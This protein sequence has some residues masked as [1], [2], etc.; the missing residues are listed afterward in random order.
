MA[1]DTMW[2]KTRGSGRWFNSIY[3][4]WYWLT[5]RGEY[6]EL[7]MR[8]PF[9]TDTIL[10]HWN[11]IRF[12]KELLSEIIE[13]Q[14]PFDVLL[15]LKYLFV[16]LP[17]VVCERS[18]VD[19]QSNCWDGKVSLRWAGPGHDT[20]RASL[21]TTNTTRWPIFTSL[22]PHGICSD[23]S[24]SSHSFQASLWFEVI[25]VSCS[26]LFL[27]D[28]AQDYKLLTSKSCFRVK[29]ELRGFQSNRMV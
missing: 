4:Y 9:I 13:L 15:P 2:S 23:I 25:E 1:V 5:F 7:R 16:I 11:H 21:T 18:D 3:S 12:N 6:S 17:C 10:K 27:F 24:S 26:F 20:G 19:K 29:L 14:Y 22:H 28:F 8:I